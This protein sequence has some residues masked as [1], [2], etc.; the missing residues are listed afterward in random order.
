MIELPDDETPTKFLAT[1]LAETVA[2]TV[3]LQN[4]PGQHDDIVA[5][6]GM[7][8][9]DLAAKPETGRASISSATHARSPRRLPG[10]RV[11]LRRAAQ[12]GP[13]IPSG[14]IIMPGTSNSPD[15]AERRARLR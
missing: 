9:V 10:K 4:P 8:T 3:E 11:T 7:V 2:S 13:R 14:A 12:Q 6:V 15:A 5:A 1:R